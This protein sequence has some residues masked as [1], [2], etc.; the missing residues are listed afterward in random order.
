M[1]RIHAWDGEI[2]P[3]APSRRP[4]MYVY[5]AYVCLYLNLLPI[6]NCCLYDFR[7]Q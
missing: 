6:I 4:R 3:L 1:P 7:L 5:R 2:T